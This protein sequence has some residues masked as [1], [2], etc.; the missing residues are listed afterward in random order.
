MTTLPHAARPQK[1]AGS[2]P[3]KLTHDPFVR[4]TVLLPGGLSLIAP[5]SLTADYDID[6][7]AGFGCSDGD[8]NGGDVHG[9]IDWGD[10]GE[11]D[12][13][14]GQEAER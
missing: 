2:R 1:E 12:F 10:G 3:L 5:E 8:V 13:D 4:L 9:T 7:T 11:T 6:M 14:L